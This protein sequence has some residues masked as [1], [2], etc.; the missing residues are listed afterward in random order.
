MNQQKLSSYFLRSFEC[1]RCGNGYY[2]E[3]AYSPAPSL[4][5]INN[6][7]TY[8]SN[9]VV[10]EEPELCSFIDHQEK[11]V[12]TCDKP[13][14]DRKKQLCRSHNRQV[15]KRFDEFVKDKSVSSTAAWLTAWDQSGDWRYFWNLAEEK[16]E[17]AVKNNQPK[18]SSND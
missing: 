7:P 15:R 10:E 1:D 17:K 18:A 3:T 2:D 9:C 12:I 5:E 8:C 14:F 6:Y 16:K 11:E 4:K 13:L